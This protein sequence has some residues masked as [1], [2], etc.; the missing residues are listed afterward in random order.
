M[1]NNVLLIAKS[2]YPSNSSGV[3]RPIANTKYLPL[4]GWTPVVVCKK[5]TLKNSEGTYDPLLEDLVDPCDTIRVNAFFNSVVNRME[6]KFWNYFGGGLHDYRYPYIL[7]HKMKNASEQIVKSRK[8]D[9][10]WATSF[11]GLTY[12]IA[13]YLS[14]KYSIPWVADFRDLPDQSYN[15][16]NTKYVVEQEID[17]C[18]SAKALIAVTEELTEK[19]KA[20]HKVP[21]YTIFNGFDPE[22]Y[23]TS[24]TNR[25]YDDRFTINHFGYI[26]K[27]RDPSPLFVAID[28]LSQKNKID[29]NNISVNFYGGNPKFLKRIAKAYHCTSQVHSIDRRPYPEMLKCQKTSQIL[30]VLAP[31]QQG[32]AIPGKLYS[33]LASHRPILNIPGDGAGTDRIIQ[34]TKAG[35][36]LS[37]P[38]EIAAWLEKAYNSWKQTGTVEFCGD[39]CEIQKYSRKTQA[40]QLAE[41]LNKII[42][43]K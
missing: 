19:L 2:Y 35:V 41:I 25:K 20:R 38:E 37:K 24:K 4:F 12:K 5:F 39:K 26:Y 17:T 42:F 18:C 6:I 15:N 7:Y 22:E 8:I 34:Q 14:R 3:H 11:P 13:D 9:A 36:S 23:E 29:L 40:G 10:I 16:K 32:G 30:L 28:T 21:A 43:E 1:Q 27:F 33:Y 31:P